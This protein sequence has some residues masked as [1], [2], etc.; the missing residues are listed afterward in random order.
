MK[1]VLR[2]SLWLLAG[3]QFLSLLDEREP[4]SE[5]SLGYTEF[6]EL[7][8]E[9]QASSWRGAMLKA[10]QRGWVQ[11]RHVSGRGVFQLTRAGKQ[12]IVTDFQAFRQVIR[13]SGRVCIAIKSSRGRSSDLPGLRTLLG[14]YSG[15]LL[16]PQLWI[17]PFRE[18]PDLLLQ[19]IQRLGFQSLVLSVPGESSLKQGSLSEWLVPR[20]QESSTYLFSRLEKTIT[21]SEE[22]LN[23]IFEKKSLHHLQIAQIGSIATDL[24]SELKSV[25]WPALEDAQLLSLVLRAFEVVDQLVV[26]WFE[27][28]Q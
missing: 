10:S 21:Q 13:R 6:Q 14:T 1:Q 25:S 15:Y 9:F 16:T 23:K 18:V 28:N 19:Q 26:E 4:F 22:L 20:A 2:E 27:S 5:V 7:R 24:L 17:L 12:E 3:G 11:K 8:P